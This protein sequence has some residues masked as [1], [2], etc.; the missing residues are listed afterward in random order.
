MTVAVI[1]DS[2]ACLTPDM[3][4]RAGLTV[5]PI[6]VVIDGRSYRDGVDITSDEVAAALSGGSVVS[7]SKP[8][9][10][11]F[12]AVYTAAAQAGATEIVSVHVSAA[13]S[14]TY[15]SARLAARE[16]SVPVTVVDS[17]SIVMGLGFAAMTAAEAVYSGADAARAAEAARLSAAE[18]SVLFYVDT[19]EF[20][21]RGGRI[22]KASAWL[23]GA[24][25]VKPL[26]H[27]DDG[28]VAPL[29]KA[30]TANRALGRLTELAVEA[31]ADRPV[32]LAVQHLDAQERAEG[33]A[34][35]LRNKLHAEVVVCE[36]TAV[37]GVHVGPGV[38]AV[39]VAPA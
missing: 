26:L 39:S 5:V 12:L 18:S 35:R 4:A 33:M 16:A 28:V 23:G 10:Q 11:E 22:G 37:M 38:V 8:T 34:A 21:R 3:A 32:R 13:L 30:R 6:H 24:L 17:H 9:P 25:R 19:L 7:T 20:L 31:A 14:G 2:T 29:E 1:T 36:V 15:D 27:V